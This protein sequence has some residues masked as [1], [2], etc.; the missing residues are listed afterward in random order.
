MDKIIIT[1]ATTGN[2]PTRKMNP[3]VPA[4]PEEIAADIYRCHQEG[5]SLAHVH[6]RDSHGEPTADV[7]VFKDVMDRVKAK[8]D[9]VML[10]STGARGGKTYEERAAPIALKPEMAS[11]ATGSSN[12]ATRVNDNPPD[13][14][15][16][17]ARQMLEHDVKPE[18]EV[19]DVAMISNAEFLA[20]RGLIKTPMQFNLVMNVPGSIK[21]TPKN[22]LHMIEILPGGSTWSVTGVGTAHLPMIT[23]GIAL[24]GNIRVGLEDVLEL[25]KG[26]SVS[27]VELVKRAVSIARA[28]GR[29][30]ASPEETRQ[31]L[32]L[33]PRRSP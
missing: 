4:T 28:Y 25:E 12:F 32:G 23:M 33:P 9:A 26:V 8:C 7:S 30:P 5:A 19:F 31:L 3:Y 24:G 21:G 2:V 22:L 11:F 6:V 16:Y 15:E 20:S 18:I 27:N 17:L 29:E 13:F 1:V 14:L 10:L